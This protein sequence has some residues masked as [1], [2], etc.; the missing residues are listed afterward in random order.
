MDIVKD[1]SDKVL[2]YMTCGQEHYVLFQAVTVLRGL[3][4]QLLT[5]PSPAVGWGGEMDKKIKL[6]G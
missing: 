2:S 5:H 1:L 3:S 4:W 6:V